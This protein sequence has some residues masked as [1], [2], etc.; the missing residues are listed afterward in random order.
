[1]RF[2]LTLNPQFQ[3][4]HSFWDNGVGVCGTANST[5]LGCMF[6]SS[7]INFLKLVLHYFSNWLWTQCY[8][9]SLCC[10][11]SIND[12]QLHLSYCLRELLAPQCKWFC[13]DQMIRSESGFTKFRFEDD[14]KSWKIGPMLTLQCSLPTMSHMCIYFIHDVSVY[15]LMFV[16]A[17]ILLI[18]TCSASINHFQITFTVKECTQGLQNLNNWCMDWYATWATWVIHQVMSFDLTSGQSLR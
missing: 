7:P 6:A 2:P 12:G 13:T 8:L 5:V 16:L 15:L 18:W 9:A 3:T 1:M 11:V 14:T 4:L 10:I 17:Q